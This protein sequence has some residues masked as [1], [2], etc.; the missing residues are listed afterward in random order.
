MGTSEHTRATAR[1]WLAAAC[2]IAALG[3]LLAACSGDDSTSASAGGEALAQGSTTTTEVDTAPLGAEFQPDRDA[4]FGVEDI[5]NDGIS[6]PEGKDGLYGWGAW[7]PA[8][9]NRPLVGGVSEEPISLETRK[10][11]GE[12]LQ[13]ARE[14]A[15]AVGTVAEAE[16][17]G[18]VKL[19]EFLPG[20]GVQYANFDYI[21]ETFD[22]DHPEVLAFPGDEPDTGI[23]AVAYYVIAGEDQPP[24]DDLP[25]DIIPWHSH[26]AICRKGDVWPL[27]QDEEGCKALGGEIVE[28]LSGWMLDLWIVP[29]WENPWG[30]L[31]SK[32]PDLFLPEEG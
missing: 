14:A 31:S 11:L 24:P 10:F 32:H 23:A 3:S 28:G 1:P 8:Q 29:G 21:D 26:W 12:Q 7:Q 4:E 6:H 2:C 16:A 17:A 27:S 22:I 5:S 19:H 20:R 18:Y 25:T 15:L 30:L 13:L 9:M